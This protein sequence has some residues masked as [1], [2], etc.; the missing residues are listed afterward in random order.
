MALAPFWE[1]GLCPGRLF[2]LMAQ[3][4]YLTLFFFKHTPPSIANAPT[5]TQ[6]LQK[7]NVVD[8]KTY[9]CYR[10]RRY[11]HHHNPTR[12]TK[13]RMSPMYIPEL[14]FK[15]F[16]F[17]DSRTVSHIVVLVCRRWFLMIYSSVTN[18]RGIYLNEDE[19]NFLLNKALV[20]LPWSEWFKW[21][22]L[23]PFDNQGIK[24]RVG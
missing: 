13:K 17:M 20:G 7:L 11:R 4:F 24:S 16:S 15:I 12:R 14:L 10:Q 6:R 3:F 21:H 22:S 23:S 9:K 19:T 5:T 18:N 2:V 8:T 1:R